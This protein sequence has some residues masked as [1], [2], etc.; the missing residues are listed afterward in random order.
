[1]AAASGASMRSTLPTVL[2]DQGFALR[3]EAEA[4]VPF[5]RKLYISTRWEELAPV[6]DWTEAHKIA[7]LESQFGFQRRHYYTYFPDSE[8]AVIEQNGAPAGRIYID[9]QETLLL[10]ID[11]ALLP[12]WRGHGV[13]TAL[14]NAVCAEARAA[15]K[16]VTI[17]VEK[18]NPAQRLYRRLGFIETADEGVHWTMEWRAA[19]DEALG[20]KVS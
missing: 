4:D 9:R 16:K 19:P 20:A 3:P 10:V 18:F 15:N 1:M 8:F 14:M 2:T 12:E 11:I 5:L 7:F 6:V 13:G 17:C